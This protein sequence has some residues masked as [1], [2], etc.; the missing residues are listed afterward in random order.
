VLD[1][2]NSS[3][4][5]NFQNFGLTATRQA[6]KVGIQKDSTNGLSWLEAGDYA[7]RIPANESSVIITPSINTGIAEAADMPAQFALEQNY[8]N[9]FNP[10]THVRIQMR[11]TGSVS[12]RIF[13]VLGREVETLVSGEKPPGTYE[14]VWDASRFASGTY[15]YRLSAGE[16]SQVRKMILM[17]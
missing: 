7:E 3:I 17:K 5:I 13:D 1:A 10:T 14:L 9:P 11:V 6:I 4:T 16:F 8:P 12:L 15:F 2:S